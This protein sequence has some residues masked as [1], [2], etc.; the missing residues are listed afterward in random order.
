[1]NTFQE[2]L[3][4]NSLT[5]FSEKLI[6]AT[7]YKKKDLTVIHTESLNNRCEHY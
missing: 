5:P 3:P 2:L 1:M 7:E 4:P 6:K